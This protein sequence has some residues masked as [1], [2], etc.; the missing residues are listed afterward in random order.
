MH[1]GLG[2]DDG[3]RPEG[4]AKNYSEDQA[5]ESARTPDA[6]DGRLGVI[7][8]LTALCLLRPGQNSH[9]S[10]KPPFRSCN[11]L[12]DWIT[13][14][15]VLFCRSLDRR[16]HGAGDIAHHLTHHGHIIALSHDPDERL[17]PRG[18]NEKPA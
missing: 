4:D 12:H 2:C 14:S 11:V 3:A 9:V 10:E 7:E 6:I 13:M 1:P 8:R 18:A 17:R 5:G 15:T 16:A